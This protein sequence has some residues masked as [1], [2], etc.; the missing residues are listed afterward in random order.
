MNVKELI[1]LLSRFEDD[2]EVLAPCE[3]YGHLK[4]I[5]PRD[6]KPDSDVEIFKGKARLVISITGGG[7]YD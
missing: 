1:A 7:R 4:P 3:G 5:H 6:V 2:T